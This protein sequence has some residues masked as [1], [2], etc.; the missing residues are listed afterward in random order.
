MKKIVLVC[1]LILTLCL[2]LCSCNMSLGMGSFS[3]EKVH[4]Y[5]YNFSGCLTI[6]KWYETET[7]VEVKTKEWGNLFLSEGT[8]FLVDD[9][10]P[11]CSYAAQ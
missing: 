9:A 7:G 10:C 11:I 8:Y 6:E 2:T 5:T 3:F 4:L 1:T